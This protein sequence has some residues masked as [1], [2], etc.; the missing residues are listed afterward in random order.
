MFINARV[1]ARAL[2]RTDPIGA[3]FHGVGAKNA[4]S[5]AL[6]MIIITRINITTQI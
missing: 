2:A 4:K 1:K 6:N 3:A 5:R